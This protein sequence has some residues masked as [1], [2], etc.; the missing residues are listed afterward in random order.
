MFETIAE[1]FNRLAPTYDANLLYQWVGRAETAAIGRLLPLERGAA[2]D[3]GCGTGRFSLPLAAQG[4]QVTGFDIASNM[5]AQAQNKAKQ[6]GIAAEFTDDAAAIAD[7][8]WPLVLCM[9]VLDYYREPVTL[10]RLVV[11]RVAPGGTLIVG[12]PNLYGPFSWGHALICLFRLRMYLH[13][14]A[15]LIAAAERLGMRSASVTYAF[16]AI[17]PVGM[18]VLIALKWRQDR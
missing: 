12:A 4:Y 10:L 8:R 2:L 13:T 16:P 3:Y 17:A 11:P 1:H 6:S 18:T 7:R 15:G 9:G 5:V 14:A